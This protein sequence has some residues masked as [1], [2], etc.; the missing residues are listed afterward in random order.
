MATCTPGSPCGS[1]GEYIDAH[2]FP[3]VVTITLRNL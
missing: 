1:S 3:T 2:D